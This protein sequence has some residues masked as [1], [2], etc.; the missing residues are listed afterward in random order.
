VL[1]SVC[2]LSADG[3][4][5]W[6]KQRTNVWERFK[7]A[8]TGNPQAGVLATCAAAASF[9]GCGSH[10]ARDSE[11]RCDDWAER[12]YAGKRD[13]G[14][15]ATQSRAGSDW[16]LFDRHDWNVRQKPVDRQFAET[17]LV[18]L[19]STRQHDAS[20]PKKH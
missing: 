11:V 13:A 12:V 2:V 4:R 3:K 16:R 19:F 15:G 1:V 6:I 18:S 8:I 17:V 14:C 20:T 9:A 7:G 10:V 5:A